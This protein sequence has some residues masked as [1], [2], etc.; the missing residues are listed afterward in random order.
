ML[1]KLSI[2]LAKLLNAKKQ[3]LQPCEL[4]IN[5]AFYISFSVTTFQL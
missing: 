5:C 3:T 4:F 1:A 2:S